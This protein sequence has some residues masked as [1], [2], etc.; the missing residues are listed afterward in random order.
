MPEHRDTPTAI[1]FARSL[2]QSGEGT[3]AILVRLRAEG[4][5]ILQCIASMREV[6]GMSL[7]EAK[8]IVHS[9]KAWSDVIPQYEAL[10]E[11]LHDQVER[12]IDEWN[13]DNSS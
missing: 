13:L 8:L 3:E 10:Q 5:S 2:Q 1:R 7:R 6:G 9:S 11:R 12:I 4:F